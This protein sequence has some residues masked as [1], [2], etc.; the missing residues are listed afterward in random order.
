MQELVGDVFKGV[1]CQVELAT[2]NT[3]YIDHVSATGT[4]YGSLP[5]TPMITLQGIRRCKN[6]GKLINEIDF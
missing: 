6:T 5:V 4:K 1:A 2:H 3:P